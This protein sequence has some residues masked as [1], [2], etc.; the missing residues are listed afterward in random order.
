MKAK[1]YYEIYFKNIEKEQYTEKC[2]YFFR[3][4]LNEVSEIAKQRKISIPSSM[5]AIFKEQQ[6]KVDAVD[7]LHKKEKGFN[8]FIENGFIDYVNRF[9]PEFKNLVE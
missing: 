6:Q 4:I 2:C 7:R 9:M 1:E 3:E 8:I 5:K